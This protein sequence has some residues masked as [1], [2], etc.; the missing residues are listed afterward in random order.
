MKPTA[1]KNHLAAIHIAHKAL[2][3]SKDDAMHLK[4]SITGTASAGDMT[5]QQRKRYLAHLSGLQERAGLIAP[6]PA[7]RPYVQRSAADDLDERW[8]KARVLWHALA[9]A[10][11]VHHDTDAALMAY[12]K[13][14]TKLEHWRFLNSYQVNAVIEALKK[15]CARCDGAAKP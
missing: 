2:G 9:V 12:V 6:R 7:K 15:W 13:R 1:C 11:A 5:E 3:L 4:L 14:Q 10:G 8:G